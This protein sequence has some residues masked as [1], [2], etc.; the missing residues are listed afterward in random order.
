[1]NL[2]RRI[3]HLI[4][5][6]SPERALRRK[7]ARTK[8]ELSAT[9]HRGADNSRLMADWILG[10][11]NPTP[12]SWELDTLRERSRDLNRNDPVACGA[13]D[14]L[15][16][17]IVGSGLSPQSKI[18]ASML[19]ISD[20]RAA[21][22]QKQAENIFAEWSVM[23]DA[24]NRLNFDELQFLAIRKIIEDGEVFAIPTWA[25]EPWRP[26]GRVIEMAESE[27][28]ASDAEDYQQG[29][30]L[31][32]RG[33]PVSYSFSVGNNTDILS[34]PTFQKIPARDLSGRPN[35]LHVFKTNRIGQIRGVPAFAPAM[36]F[37]KHLSD[38]LEAEVVSARV[39]A[40]L[41][42]FVTSGDPMGLA[43]ANASGT[44]TD[45]NRIQAIEPGLV[46]YLGT[47]ESINVVD[48]KRPGDAFAPFVEGVL[49]LI[50]V[51][52]GMPYE[53]LLKDFSKTNYSSAR[54]A[55]LE[56]R[57]HFLN[58]RN[59]FSKKFCQP[60][61]DLVLEEAFLR[62]KFDAPDFYDRKN[63]YCR[64]AWIGGAWGWVDPVKEVQ[65]SKLAM[66]YGLS[67]LAEEV[68]G[69]GRDWEEVLEQKAKEM[70]RINDLG[71]NLAPVES[72]KDAAP[73]EQKGKTP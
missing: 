40:C 9:L 55:L 70:Q 73:A 35:V 39:A 42:V 7:E 61:W 54:A 1:M 44:G 36:S 37:F 27:R 21:E 47:G 64:C 46:H 19:G 17:N 68:A 32:T 29:I 30:K 38:Y 45:G 26:F 66:D 52:L 57:R 49:R 18:R 69:Q 56:G 13:T 4:S 12:D 20:T 34:K 59:W 5:I 6:F 24:G 14:T 25:D 43:G 67:T 2:S 62:G 10:R 71:L 11:S 16:I 48:P 33:Q 58:W 8:L 53:L 22:L 65:A 63:E 51:S 15:G 28:C 41:A 3:D 60:I 23:A 72:K 31:G 50:G